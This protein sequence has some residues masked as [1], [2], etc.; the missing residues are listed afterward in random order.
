M[1]ITSF[2]GIGV[3]P[4][5]GELRSIVNT[6]GLYLAMTMIMTASVDDKDDVNAD[7]ADDDDDHDE[8][9]NDEDDYLCGICGW[10]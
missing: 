8:N 9:D 4:S 1:T 2:S 3:Q 7:N 6:S 5:E 10:L